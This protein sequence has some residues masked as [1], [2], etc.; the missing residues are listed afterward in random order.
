MAPAA[1]RNPP[2]NMEM[3]A[4]SASGCCAGRHPQEKDKDKPNEEP[5][6]GTS[7][8]TEQRASHEAPQTRTGLTL[9]LEQ[10]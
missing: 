6:P 1:A 4:K 2:T 10:S 9:N 5:G 3:A 7:E 8:R